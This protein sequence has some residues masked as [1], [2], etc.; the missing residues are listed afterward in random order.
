MSN[1]EKTTFTADDLPTIIAAQAQVAQFKAFLL[2]RFIAWTHTADAKNTHGGTIEP[3]KG[4]DGRTSGG[5]GAWRLASTTFTPNQG[6]FVFEHWLSD[7][8][9]PASKIDEAYVPAVFIFASAD[10]QA[11]YETFL[12]LKAR[13]EPNA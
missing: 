13:F 12:A 4:P 6:E 1:A 3:V 2:D 8:R 5:W 7:E 11:D 9:A 10:E